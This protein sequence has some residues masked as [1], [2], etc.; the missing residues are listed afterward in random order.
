MPQV[1]RRSG[2]LWGIANL[3]TLIGL[4]GTVYGLIQSF[5]AVGL[6]A[7]DQKSVLLTEGIAHAMANTFFGLSIAVTCVFFHMIL[8][9]LVKNVMDGVD[10][11]AVRIEN[12]L[13]KRRIATGGREGASSTAQAAT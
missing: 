1:T 7:P 8:S 6:A 2:I 9:V 10:H 4:V 3:A 12:I 11:S 5:A 13:A